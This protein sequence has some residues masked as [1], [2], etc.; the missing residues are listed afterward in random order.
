MPEAPTPHPVAPMPQCP[1]SGRTTWPSAPRSFAGP[2]QRRQPPA[3]AVGCPRTASST[4]SKGLARVRRQS[5]LRS[6]WHDPC[7]RRHC[8]K[9]GRQ[10]L[11]GVRKSVGQNVRVSPNVDS[12]L[13]PSVTWS[14][15]CRDRGK[16]R[17]G[18][19]CGAHATGRVV[20]SPSSVA[21]VQ[22]RAELGQDGRAPLEV[23]S[24]VDM[25]PKVD[26]TWCAWGAS[27]W[28]QWER[29]A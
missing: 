10:I 20:P 9:I 18:V 26:T 22:Q 11:P 1:R 25:S 19:D 23:S 13:R 16:C 15:Q 8:P 28:R 3:I 21:L 7:A 5:A 24:K 2:R 27:D 29:R 17:L 4:P 12:G 6:A 14:G